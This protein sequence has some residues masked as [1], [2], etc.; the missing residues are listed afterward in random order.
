MNRRERQALMK[1]QP[2]SSS[3]PGR[4][5]G[6]VHV[7]IRRRD[8]PQADGTTTTEISLDLREVPIPERRYVADT[9]WV[10]YQN[11]FVRFMFAQR[12]ISG[13][14][15]RSVVIVNVYPEPARQIVTSSDEFISNIHKFMEKNGIAARK[16]VALTEEPAQTVA[17][18]SNMMSVT[19]AGREA[20]WDFFHLPPSGMKKIGERSDLVVD[21]VV[22]IDLATSMVAGILEALGQLLPDLPQEAR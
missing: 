9:A 12:A 1:H 13:E 22:R 17:L 21:A 18:T 6:E 11:E 4:A 2:R 3:S 8:V 5:S 7:P 16:M 20:E 19:F 10:D 15:L 14:K